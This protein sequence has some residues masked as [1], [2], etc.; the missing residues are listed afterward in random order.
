VKIA[1]VSSYFDAFSGY[2]EVNLVKQLRLQGHSVTVVSS[3]KR[4]PIFSNQ[5]LEIL[6]EK[7]SLEPSR[8]EKNIGGEVRLRPFLDWRSMVL[9]RGTSTALRV[10]DP[11][12]VIIVMPSQAF[13]IGA[14]PFLLSP[15]SR[16]IPL[17][18]LCGDNR[19]Q[20][21]NLIGPARVVKRGLFYLFKGPWFRVLNQRAERVF[22]HTPNT[23]SILRPLSPPHKLSLLP[24][25][26]DPDI[27]YFSECLR[28]Q[29]RKRLGVAPDEILIASTGKFR[30]E[31]KLTLLVDS[32]RRIS[33][34]EPK[35]KLLLVGSNES[36]YSR[37][38]AN[39]VKAG[40]EI[41]SKVTLLPF[42]PQS[43]INAYLNA[44]DVGAWPVQPAVSIQQALGTGLLTVIP[45]NDLV[46]HLVS[47]STGAKISRSQSLDFALRE[48]IA[49]VRRQDS[50]KERLSR[51]MRSRQLF[52]NEAVAQ[53]VLKALTA[54]N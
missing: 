51:A 12:A 21:N 44:A 31:K 25:A 42:A 10:I 40:K 48:L 2:Q 19:A 14:L 35:V 47:P 29:T 46:S 18:V 41:S 50:N 5:V 39:Y 34:R 17:V 8:P 30:W 49:R 38:L 37:Y 26:Y 54:D 32:L 4:N 33:L 13:P 1:V 43:E 28:N 15:R 3:T 20:Y 27:F 24:L 16:N 36:D 7:R 45:D 52:S 9:S 23:I 53:T 22:G 6:G 11:D